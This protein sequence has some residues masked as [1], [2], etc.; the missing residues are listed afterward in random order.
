MSS[1]LFQRISK[2]ENSQKIR[3]QNHI[4]F[5]DD[6][7]EI[8]ALDENGKKK[9]HIYV[10]SNTGRIFSQDNS[11]VQLVMGPYGSGKTT[12]C[13][14]KIVEKAAQMPKWH[15]GRRKS[16]CI[17][18]R[19]TS[20][21][22]YSTTLKSWLAWFGEMG[23][24]KPRKKPILTYE[25]VFSDSEGVIELELMFIALDRDDDIRKLKSLEATM[26][27]INELSEV[28]QSVLSHLKG[29]LN[30][31]Y[32]SRAFCNEYYWSGIFADTNPPDEDHWIYRDFEIN[33]VEGYKIFKQPPGLIKDEYGDWIDNRSADNAVNLAKHSHDNSNILVYDYYR[34][35]ATGQSEEFIKVFCLGKYGLVESG[36]RVY[37]EYNDDF[38]SIDN[39]EAIQGE[40]IHLTWDGG[41]TPACVVIQLSSRGQLI[42]L[43]EYLAEDMGV[44]SFA[45]NVVI[46]SL[47][48][49][50]PY[51]PILINYNNSGIVNMLGLSIGDPS[52]VR[53]EEVFGNFS[54]IGELNE[55]GIKTE[56]AR[57]NLIDP[58]INAV[59]YFLNKSPDGKPGLLLDRKKCP[60]IRKGFINGYVY[61]R[62][63]VS[64]DERYRNEPDKNKFSHPHDCIQ[65]GALEFAGN[66]TE[67][68]K[69]QYVSMYNPTF[70]M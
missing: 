50:F 54:F 27:Y 65:Y 56:P 59:K 20:P 63:S 46:P 67:V 11:F 33:K 21:E 2:L 6:R 32:P 44:R 60:I 17:I 48:K 42:I 29:R 41:L 24:V 7:T 34:K 43:K 66:S 10:P 13:L 14:Q 36:K 39:I 28:P 30:G 26:A 31:R 61:K 40:P 55:L 53:R 3:S 23:D 58:R 25:H 9:N 8:Y 18:I 22:L 19:N 64:G 49:D 35:L 1:S 52:G 47:R 16:R 62:L 12:M 68:V 57:T 51:H 4:W 15:N 37:P 38:H 5:Y 69:K 70:R 45:E